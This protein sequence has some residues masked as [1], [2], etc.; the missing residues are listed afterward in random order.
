[1]VSYLKNSLIFLLCFY[2]ASAI[3]AQENFYQSTN[4]ELIRITGRYITDSTQNTTIFD[5]S[6]TQ[7]NFAL[8]GTCDQVLIKIETSN[9]YFNLYFN[10]ILQT[11][12]LFISKGTSEYLIGTKLSGT[13]IKLVKRSEPLFATES[14]KFYGVKLSGNCTLSNSIEPAKANLIEFIGDSDTC[15]YGNEGAPNQKYLAST[16]NADN[17]YASQVAKH[18]NADFSLVCVSGIGA[19][20]SPSDKDPNMQQRYNSLTFFKN[21]YNNNNLAFNFTENPA[22]PDLIVVYLGGNDWFTLNAYAYAQTSLDA[23]VS[24]FAQ[25]IKQIRNANPAKSGNLPKILIM[26]PGSKT[27]SAASSVEEMNLVSNTLVPLLTK[28]VELANKDAKEVYFGIASASPP[29]ELSNSSDWGSELHWSALGHK[30][31][32]NGVVP[33]VEKVTGWKSEKSFFAAANGGYGCFISSVPLGLLLVLVF[34]L[35]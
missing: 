28:A 23:F 16:Q 7:V 10:N 29:I 33:L 13:Q 20:Y 3:S 21:N 8:K 18:F 1:M 24:G 9:S 14:V 4:N 19:V 32:A 17:G 15:A 26:A 12:V 34:V 27:A 5:W 11:Q 22:K 6:A 35:F 30:K 2:S 25:L 31:F